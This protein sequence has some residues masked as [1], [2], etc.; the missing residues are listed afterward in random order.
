MPEGVGRRRFSGITPETAVPDLAGGDQLQA[1]YRF[2]DT[3]GLPVAGSE[4][5]QPQRG[6]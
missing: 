5:H 6:I 1:E 2:T 3:G 4:D